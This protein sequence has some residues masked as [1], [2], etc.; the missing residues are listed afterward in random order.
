MSLQIT[1]KRNTPASAAKPLR[2]GLAVAREPRPDASE[3]RKLTKSTKHTRR[4][5]PGLPKGIF[6]GSL[7]FFVPFVLIVGTLRAQQEAHHIFAITGARVVPVSS[8]PIDNGTVVFVDGVIT[9]VGPGVAAPEGAQIVDGKGLTVYPGLIDLGSPAGLDIPAVPRA[10]NPQ[11]TEEVERVKRDTLL[12]P[13]LRAA[14]HVNA[15]APALAKAASAGITAIL[16]TP[17]GDGV[18][19]QSALILSALPPDV[20]QISALAD[21]R[22]GP[23]VVRT[24]VALHVGVADRP[25][26]GNAYP[27][28]LMGII[29]FNRQAF[30]DAQHYQAAGGQPFSPAFAEMQTAIGRKLPVAF[31]AT[32]DREVRRALDMAASFKLDPIVTSAREVDGVA[33]VLK[34]A[35]AR[36]V[37]SLDFPRRPLSLAP[38]ADEPLNV[39][40]SRANAPKGP[41]ALDA[42]GLTFGFES[43][44][45]EDPKDFLKNAAKVVSAGL[46]SEAVLK[47]L[48]LNAA[49]IAGAS[50]RLGSIDKGKI[51]NLIVTE[52]DL[53]AEK[54]TIKH[55]FVGGRPVTIQ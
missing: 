31:R 52:G 26:G 6:V 37:Y 43:G 28:S 11:T 7:V 14:E 10:E 49:T 17:P 54:T 44:G 42:A 4:S 35:G 46:S 20:Q 30:F 29:A 1:Y 53:F 45:L 5:L 51:A 3:G 9:Q 19:G 15:A 8:A 27:N 38:E 32:T 48:T 23:L 24:P 25:A 40:K 34:S 47:A 13:H 16:A 39:L 55:V 50:D 22:R 36:V 12:R 21:D 41:Q 2:R 18:R 33:N